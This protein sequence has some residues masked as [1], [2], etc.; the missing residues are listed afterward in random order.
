MN[1]VIASGSEDATVKLWDVRGHSKD[2]I[3]TLTQFKDSIMC[4]KLTDDQIIV[5]SLDGCIRTFDIRCGSLSTDDL[6][7]PVLGMSL[8]HDGL[9]SGTTHI[10]SIIRITD[11]LNG[12]VLNAYSGSHVTLEHSIACSFTSDDKSIV[13]GSDNGDVASYNLTTGVGLKR[14]GHSECTVGVSAHPRDSKLFVSCSLDG[15]AKYWRL[16]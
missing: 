15:T 10:D 2:P 11:R 7:E 3:Q 12:E 14:Q 8:S 13:V 5:A 1:S 9:A 16:V 4:V 6:K